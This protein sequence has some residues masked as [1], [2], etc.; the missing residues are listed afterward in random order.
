MHCRPPLSVCSSVAQTFGTRP[1]S[2]KNRT[3][4][5][6]TS[7]KD[8]RFLIDF[9]PNKYRTWPLHAFARGCRCERD[10]PPIF[11]NRAPSRDIIMFCLFGLYERS[12][13][14][15]PRETIR[16]FDV[17]FIF[18]SSKIALSLETSSTFRR[19]IFVEIGLGKIALPCGASGK[20]GLF[21]CKNRAPARDILET[22]SFLSS[23]STK[24]ALP[25]EHSKIL[26]VTEQ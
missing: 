26:I 5:L 3:L 22:L 8:R 25:C 2:L 10:D 9:R 7:Q 20:L 17:L 4:S 18:V 24:I 16:F 14:A 12:T 6:E 19:F 15:L 11:K 23:K 1:C 21:I 13:I